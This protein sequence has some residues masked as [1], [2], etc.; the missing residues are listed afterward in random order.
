MGVFLSPSCD[1]ATVLIGAWSAA[2]RVRKPNQL[3]AQRAPLMRRVVTYI[4]TKTGQQRRSLVWLRSLPC[5][6][7]QV[8][9]TALCWTLSSMPPPFSPSPSSSFSSSSTCLCLTC[10]S[11]KRSTVRYSCTTTVGSDTM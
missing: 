2:V 6:P 11:M 1:T 9:A 5:T 3:S 7:P 8:G 4:C 10:F